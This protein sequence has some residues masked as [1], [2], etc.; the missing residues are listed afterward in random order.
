MVF[1][2]STAHPSISPNSL[3]SVIIAPMRPESLPNLRTARPIEPVKPGRKEKLRRRC[4]Q[5][6][7]SFDSNYEDLGDYGAD[8]V[9]LSSRIPVLRDDGAIPVGLTIDEL[10]AKLPDF[11]QAHL[12]VAEV[13]GTYT[14]TSP[15]MY[16]TACSIRWDDPREI[17]VFDS[18]IPRARLP[19]LTEFSLAIT[20]SGIVLA[21]F[22][23]EHEVP[24]DYPNHTAAMIVS[25]LAGGVERTLRR[26]LGVED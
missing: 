13:E 19:Q 25:K 10:E 3:Y 2:G 1:R 9:R 11:A 20:H 18:G 23:N 5:I 16:T 7:D 6:Y 12:E 15:D 24:F 22:L 26:K 4:V 14:L 17:V 8:I 21:G